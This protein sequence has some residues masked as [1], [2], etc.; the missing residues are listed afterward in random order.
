MPIAAA[1][2]IEYP[3]YLAPGFAS[4]RQALERLPRPRLSLLLAVSGLLPWLAYS[5]PTGQFHWQALLALTAIA[6]VVSFWY[7]IFPGRIP[8]DIAFLVLNA[9]IILGRF[10]SRIYTSPVPHLSIDILGHLMLIHIAVTAALVERRVHHIGFGFIPSR[11]ELL[12]GLKYFLYFA[13]IGFPLAWY[14]GI[15]HFHGSSIIWWQALVMLPV[16]FW[17]VALSEEFFFRGLLQQ[18]FARWT[19]NPSVGLAAAS[20]LYGL[21]HLP[22]RTFPNWRWVILTIVL[23]WFCGQAYRAAGSVRASAVSHALVVTLWRLVG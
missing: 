5:I 15:V 23:G 21:S 13:P 22:F 17:T 1:F 4:V 16:I 20:I 8:A 18:W 10:F 19:R 6:T 9:A 2:L 7:A 3:F 12:I 14:L 11:R